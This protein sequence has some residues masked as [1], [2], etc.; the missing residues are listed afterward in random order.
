MP[1]FKLE[2]GKKIPNISLS[3]VGGRTQTL[4][5]TKTA[6]SWKIIV[7]YRGLHCP[8]CKSYLAELKELSGEFKDAN[9]EILALSGDPEE[10][11]ETQLSEGDLNF[12]LA[13]GMSTD[14]MESLG[15]YIS[16]PRSE[17]ETD[18]PFPEPAA[19]ILN[20]AGELQ[21]IDISNAPFSRPELAKLLKGIQF[22]QSNGYPVRGTYNS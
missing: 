8:L 7:I 4:A 14:Q 2:A 20:A 17:K 3:L 13:Y 6:D 22:I 15:L 11:A 5:E 19:L 9:V 1:S 12:P 16:H 10:K 18:R 21:I